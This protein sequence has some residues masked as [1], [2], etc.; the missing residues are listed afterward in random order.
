MAATP[1]HSTKVYAMGRNLIKRVPAD[2]AY[3]TTE[4]VGIWVATAPTSD[5]T[6]ITP[7][8]GSALTSMTKG[9][10]AAGQIYPIHASSVT[11]GTGGVFYLL[12]P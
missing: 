1:G 5:D 6:A 9:L 11:V 8:D 10:F 3:T 2:G 4:T 7:V 12:I